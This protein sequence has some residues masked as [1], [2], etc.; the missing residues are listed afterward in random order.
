MV[1]PAYF[2]KKSDSFLHEDIIQR[3]VDT[4]SITQMFFFTLD[5]F[6]I[7]LTA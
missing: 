1:F 3:L 5:I 6:V 7:G 4:V 2:Q